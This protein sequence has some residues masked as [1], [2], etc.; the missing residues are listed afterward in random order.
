MMWLDIMALRVGVTHGSVCVCQHFL[1][2][3]GVWIAPSMCEPMN[4]QP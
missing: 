2:H 1:T 3:V 4:Q